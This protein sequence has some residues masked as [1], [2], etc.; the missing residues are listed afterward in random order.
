MAVEY[1]TSGG[2]RTNFGPIESPTTKP[3]AVGSREAVAGNVKQLEYN[4]TFNA[5]PA[6]SAT[7]VNDA[8]VPVLPAHSLIV[9]AILLVEEAFVGGT[10]LEVGTFQAVAG[11]AVNASGIIPAAVG[12]TANLNAV[13]KGVYGTGILC[14]NSLYNTGGAAPTGIILATNGTGAITTVVGV[15]AVGTYTAGRARLLISYIDR[16]G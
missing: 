14:L 7:N 2:V 16:I 11:T 8:L 9:D 3:L 10:S 4:F 5:L 13:G 15:V 6:W 12:I 1:T